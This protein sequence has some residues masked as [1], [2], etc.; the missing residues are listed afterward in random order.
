MSGR[1][2]IEVF[3]NKSVDFMLDYGGSAS[4]VINRKKAGQI[5]YCICTRNDAVP[6]E[7]DDGS[8]DEERNEA[9]LVG[10][11]SGISFVENQND[12]DRYLIKFSHFAEV[13]VPDFRKSMLRNP[14]SY[15]SVEECRER[16][17]DISSLQFEKM[18]EPTQTYERKSA[19]IN[20]PEL[21]A[22]PLTIGEAKSRLAESLGI[23]TDCIEIV[24]RG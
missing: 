1:N 16:G 9:F 7:D 22:A 14:V 2:V 24:I 4:W 3:T 12:R 6:R 11:V 10:R 19:R 20:K 21:S 18:P 23:S 17:L 8:R 13:S 5:E 15:S